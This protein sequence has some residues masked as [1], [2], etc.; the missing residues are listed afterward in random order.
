MT[1]ASSRN[2]STGEYVPRREAAFD[3][4]FLAVPRV[5]PGR[6]PGGRD[7]DGTTVLPADHERHRIRGD[8]DPPT[9]GRRA[10]PRPARILLRPKRPPPRQERADLCGQDPAR[11]SA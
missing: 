2:G 4:S 9:H 7:P 5:R 3:P 1:A 11:R 6:G 10:D 8:L